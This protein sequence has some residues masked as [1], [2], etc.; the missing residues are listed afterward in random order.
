MSLVMV[1]KSEII[2]GVHPYPSCL[3]TLGQDVKLK[4]LDDTPIPS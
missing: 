1:N 3:V 4:K 2:V